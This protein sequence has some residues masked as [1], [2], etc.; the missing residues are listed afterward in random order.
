MLEQIKEE[1]ISGP[2]A[3]DLETKDP[4][5]ISHYPAWVHPSL[6]GHIAGICIAN[7]T[8]EWYIPIGH[9]EGENYDPIPTIQQLDEILNTGS[10]PVIFFNAH[11]DY[12]WLKGRHGIKISRPI[13]DGMLAEPLLN[14]HKI[15][16]SLDNT[17]NEYFKIKKAETALKQETISRIEEANEKNYKG[18]IWKLPPECVAEYGKQDARLTY[19]LWEAQMPKIKNE[20]LEQVLQ[21]ELD[22]IEVLIDVRLHGVRIDV[23]KIPELKKKYR[24]KCEEHLE[25]LSKMIGH[26]VLLNGKEVDAYRKEHPGALV[27]NAG[28]STQMAK[29]CDELGL[30]YTKTEKGTPSFAEDNIHP[31]TKE[32]AR[33]I[34]LAKRY[35]NKV[36][37]TYL[38]GY[39]EHYLIGD[40]IHAQY[41]QLRS[42]EG[43]TITGRFSCCNPNLQ[44]IPARDPEI[45]PDLM[46]LFLPDEDKVFI[47]MDYSAQ[48]PRMSVHLAVTMGDAFGDHIVHGAALARTEKFQ[49]RDSDFHSEV[50]RAVISSFWKNN[51]EEDYY[52]TMQWYR[53]QPEDFESTFFDWLVKCY[54]TPAKEIGLGTMYSMGRG[55]LQ[56][57]L[58]SKGIYLSKDEVKELQETVFEAVPFLKTIDDYCKLK[59]GQRG[60]ICTVMKRR[61]RFNG[62]EF[63]EF[64][65]E[66]DLDEEGNEIEKWKVIRHQYGSIQDATKARS[67]CLLNGKQVGPIG[68]RDE[69]KALNKYIQGSSADQSKCAVLK[70]YQAGII[71]QLFIHDSQIQSINPS[72]AQQ[73][74][75]IME[76]ALP[77]KVESKVDYK[78]GNNWSEVK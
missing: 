46:S 22:L 61:N 25:A 42:D 71:P 50:A 51:T 26:K 34:I 78:L 74:V 39:I 10:H 32:F 44:N 67:D 53:E 62:R 29:L 58:E 12:G 63:P 15:S 65:L 57:K 77:L 4:K 20:G 66:K 47:G 40:R 49:S 31:E 52:K 45:G 41:N 27:Y 24:A 72:Q 6:E 14:E 48:E 43:G 1:L 75:D 76:H 70:T 30:P 3:V 7:K 68:Y 23:T 8:N 9:E 55:K 36:I 13:Y 2:I 64:I 59:A 54:R 35:G 18:Y 5:L 56:E 69:Y 33:H 19:D 38:E 21:L 73:C 60:Y 16:Y 37:G 28:S 11:Y 17:A